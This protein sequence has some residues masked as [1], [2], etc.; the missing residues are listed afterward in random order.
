MAEL[1]KINRVIGKFDQQ[2]PHETRLV[3]D[4]TMGQNAI[5]Q[6]EQ[7]CAAVNVTGLVLTKL[8]GSAR[9][10]VIFALAEQFKLPIRYVGVGEAAEDL[11]VFD[12]T[13]FVLDL[14]D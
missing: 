5:N 9:G 1:E 2:A 12:A 7:F 6:A 13:A 3:L 4:A 14:L 11:Q 8:D 10:G